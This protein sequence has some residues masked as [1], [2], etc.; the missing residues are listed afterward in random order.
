MISAYVVPRATVA[1]ERLCRLPATIVT[2]SRRIPK[3]S[4]RAL[5]GKLESA[6]EYI[7]GAPRTPTVKRSASTGPMRAASL[8][9]TPR[10]VARVFDVTDGHHSPTNG[11]YS[12][13]GGF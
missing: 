12:A 9:A 4:G 10:V 1:K 3:T 8:E 11:A 6:C 2:N 13:S 5:F 7:W